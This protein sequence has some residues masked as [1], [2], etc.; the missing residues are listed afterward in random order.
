[1][2]LVWLCCLAACSEAP[3][4]PRCDDARECR[5]ARRELARLQKVCW[6]DPASEPKIMIPTPRMAYAGCCGDAVGKLE[7]KC[8]LSKE[9]RPCVERWAEACPSGFRP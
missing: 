4:V 1:V 3:S 2:R 6:E 5:D 7:V 9:L 8:G